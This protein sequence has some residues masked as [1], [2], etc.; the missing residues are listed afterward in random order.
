MTDEK[1]KIAL[2]LPLK[3]KNVLD[4]LARIKP[5][6][7]TA[8][9]KLEPYPWEEGTAYRLTDIDFPKQ[10]NASSSTDVISEDFATFAE[11]LRSRKEPL[12]QWKLWIHS[13]NTMGAFWSGTDKDQMESFKSGNFMMSLVVSTTG[14]KAA[15]NLFS[16]LR[17]D[18][19]CGILYEDNITSEEE[20]K[21]Y[22]D[23]LASLETVQEWAGYNKDQPQLPGYNHYRAWERK[24]YDFP[25]PAHSRMESAYGAYVVAPKNLS[26]EEAMLFYEL[27]D[28]GWE[29]ESIMSQI[30]A[31][32]KLAKSKK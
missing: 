10:T 12:N 25:E 11:Q 29:Y 9:G 2:V 30:K 24:D 32:R 7:W 17:G 8:F 1:P 19:D 14:M 6:E 18:F 5:K 22:A 15:F 28:A 23:K 26:D 21:T 20:L 27:Q 4:H 3:L 31:D 16:P 13:H